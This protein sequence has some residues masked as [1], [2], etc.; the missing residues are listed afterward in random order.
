MEPHIDETECADGIKKDDHDWTVVEEEDDYVQAASC[1]SLFDSLVEISIRVFC[2]QGPLKYHYGN[3]EKGKRANEGRFVNIPQRYPGLFLTNFGD[4]M[5]TVGKS[6]PK[7]E[8][9]RVEEF[10]LRQSRVSLS[11]QI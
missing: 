2:C 8:R 10:P 4:R 11:M 1:T 6:V 3:V 5:M 9:I 7:G